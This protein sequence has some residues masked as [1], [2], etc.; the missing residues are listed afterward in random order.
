MGKQAR[1]SR[2][3]EKRCQGTIVQAEKIPKVTI[4]KTRYFCK[5]LFFLI[6]QSLA[7]ALLSRRY[8]LLVHMYICI[9]ARGIQVKILTSCRELG[10][11]LR[12]NISLDFQKLL[13]LSA[14]SFSR[15]C[16]YY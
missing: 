10:S 4:K 14:S 15:R 1:T 5:H 2:E 3:V 13:K 16:C 9:V 8:V 12:T 6:N 11:R 7:L